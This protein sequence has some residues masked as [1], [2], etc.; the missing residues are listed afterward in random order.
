MCR[1]NENRSGCWGQT[2]GEQMLNPLTLRGGLGNSLSACGADNLACFSRRPV[3][4]SPARRLQSILNAQRLDGN[5]LQRS[6]LLLNG[7][8]KDDIEDRSSPSASVGLD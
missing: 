6:C 5:E 4:K 1:M 7:R 3:R 2:L 8:E